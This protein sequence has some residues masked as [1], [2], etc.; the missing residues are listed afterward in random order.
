MPYDSRESLWSEPLEHF[1]EQAL[2]PNGHYYGVVLR[3]EKSTSEKG[4][5][6]LDFYVALKRPGPDVDESALGD[7]D[8]S[9][10]ELRAR[11]FIT[12]RAMFRVRNFFQSLGQNLAL[13]LDSVLE[14]ATGA[15]VLATITKNSYK[16]NG[17]DVWVNNIDELVGASAT[18]S[19]VSQL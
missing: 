7:T 10:Y 3:Y 13:G 4:T 15:E 6:M 17:K 8:L 5:E 19:E 14:N 12:K 9:D 18:S 1:E 2:L 11:F 16:R